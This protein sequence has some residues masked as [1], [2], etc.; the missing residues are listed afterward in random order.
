MR[1]ILL[2]C[3]CAAALGANSA[4]AQEE[5]VGQNGEGDIQLA[6]LN[7]ITVYATRNPIPAF[8]YPGQ[9]TVIGR[10]VI[11]DFNPSTISDIFDAIPGASFDSGPRR[12]GDTPAIRGLA[13]E[14]VLVL[15]DGARQSFLSGHDGRF[16]IDPDLVQAV[17]VVRGPASALYGSGAL[18]GV[19]A[20]RTITASDLLQEGETAGVKIGGGFQSVNDEW[21]VSATGVWRTQDNK[22]DVVGNFTLRN[23]GN[24]E[25]GSG[26]ALPADDE[27]LSSLLKATIRP[28][29]DVTFSASWI[30]Y[31]S[32][33]VDP[34]NP[35]G[36]NVAGPGNGEVFRDTDSNTLQAVLNYA[37]SG[38]DLIDLNLVGYVTRNEVLEDIVNSPRI[39]TRQVETFGISVDNRSKFSFGERADLT[40]TYGGEY[41]R[42][43]QI[44]RDNATADGTRGGVPDATGRFYGAFA[45]AE[46]ALNRPLGAPGVLTL[47]PGVRWDRFENE[48]PG[49]PSTGDEAFSPKIGVSYKPVEA[50]IFF[51]NWSEAF[52]APSFNELFADNLHFQIP[53]R[54]V[55]PPQLVSNFFIPN[56]DLIPEESQSWEIG[57]GI[58]LDGVLFEGDGFTA[59]ASYYRSNVTNLINL[60]VNIPAGCFG[61]PFPPCGSGEA[62]DN[63]S[64]NVNVANADIDGFEMEAQYNS[65][66]FYARANFSTIDGRDADSGEFL[67]VLQPDIF[68]IDSGVKWPGPDIR[69]GARVRLASDFTKV[70]DPTL[71]RDSYAVG[72]IYAVWEPMSGPM[73]GLRLDIGVDNVTDA[74]YEIVAAGVSQSGRN[75]KAAVSWRRGF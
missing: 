15:F 72:D 56:P 21:R 55:F 48:A 75:I 10:D 65:D 8:D 66:Y 52:R 67:G 51:G 31:S 32:D 61:A 41:Y 33:S 24:I 3:V 9:V 59:K 54:S 19:I 4:W 68:F 64:R 26:I 6:Q 28:V 30:R 11:D 38:S 36:V 14:G 58:D 44:G 34:N 5:E 25:L 45:Q 50:L 43:E 70:N 27:V 18:G 57:A 2:G 53:D 71:E 40:L 74:D 39:V 23:S 22:V 13:G 29:P 17:E 73:E 16:F 49:D 60:E 62:F 42:D 47:I 7:E 69:L 20:L 1:T 35:Q 46:L 12:T 37:P 63:F